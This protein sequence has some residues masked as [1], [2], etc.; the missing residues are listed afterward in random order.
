MN[1]PHIHQF[2]KVAF[3]TWV[4]ARRLPYYAITPGALIYYGRHFE[5]KTV[6]SVVFLSFWR[7]TWALRFDWPMNATDVS[8]AKL[9]WQTR[10]FSAN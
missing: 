10:A 5:A 7:W 9:E 4:D 2:G 8:K 6:T 1:S 3:Q